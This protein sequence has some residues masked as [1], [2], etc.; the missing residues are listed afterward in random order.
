MVVSSLKTASVIVVSSARPRVR[1]KTGSVSFSCN[2]TKGCV[3]T[4]SETQTTTETKTVPG[5][6]SEVRGISGEPGY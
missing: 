3:I 1:H 6:K 2:N 4:V 5:Y